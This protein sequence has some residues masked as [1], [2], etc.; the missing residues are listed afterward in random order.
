MTKATDKKV[1]KRKQELIQ[2]GVL[3]GKKVDTVASLLVG[4]EIAELAESLVGVDSDCPLVL[5]ALVPGGVQISRTK[6]LPLAT[7]VGMIHLAL[8]KLF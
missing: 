5:I 2:A 1:E 7:C 3:K 8:D 6:D 4:Q